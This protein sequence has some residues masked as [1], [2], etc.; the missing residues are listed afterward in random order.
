MRDS[1]DQALID[2]ALG[3]TRVASGGVG[4]AGN[5]DLDAVGLAMDRYG[6]AKASPT[7]NDWE[8]QTTFNGDPLKYSDH[9]LNGEG[10]DDA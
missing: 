7:W 10:R 4:A 8:F 6:E 5:I 3:R 2:E 9:V 1:E